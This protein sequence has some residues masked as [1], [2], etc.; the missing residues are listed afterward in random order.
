MYSTT[1]HFSGIFNGDNRRSS[2]VQ[3][4]RCLISLTLIASMLLAAV[5]HTLARTAASGASSTKPFF[6]PGLG[7]VAGARSHNSWP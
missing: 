7:S 1:A 2:L 5:P 3:V 6:L 4:T